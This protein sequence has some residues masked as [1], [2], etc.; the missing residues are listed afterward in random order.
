L[1]IADTGWKTGGVA[2]EIA[3]IVTEKKFDALKAPIERV[4]CP[5]VPT[6]AGYTLEDAFYVGKPDIKTAILKIV[7]YSKRS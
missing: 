2:A 3:A 4:T 6:P 7:N 1:V 5:D